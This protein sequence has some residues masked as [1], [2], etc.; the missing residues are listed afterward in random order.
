MNA[1]PTPFV[2]LYT[3]SFTAKDAKD[4]KESFTA[5]D[6][7]DAKETIR[8]PISREAG[9]FLQRADVMLISP[10]QS[11][12]PNGQTIDYAQTETSLHPQIP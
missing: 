11:I 9:G 8:R 10:L 7:K 1:T 6:A 3:K 12:R 4:T 5:K 2:A